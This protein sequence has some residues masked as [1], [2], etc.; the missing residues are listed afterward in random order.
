[1]EKK[2]NNLP[3]HRHFSISFGFV[4]GKIVHHLKVSM[5]SEKAF[6]WRNVIKLSVLSVAQMEVLEMWFVYVNIL[7]K[8]KRIHDKDWKLNI[9]EAHTFKL[10]QTYFASCV[11]VIRTWWS[12]L[13]IMKIKVCDLFSRRINVCLYETAYPLITTV[14]DYF[15]LFSRKLCQSLMINLWRV[16]FET[17]ASQ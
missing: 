2:V 9:Y 17:E 5:A 16:A 4:V 8:R 11:R 3:S 15:S 10:K 1:M 7:R 14:L 13:T 6:E 12:S